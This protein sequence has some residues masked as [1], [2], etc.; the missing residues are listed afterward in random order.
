MLDN[1]GDRRRLQA[2]LDQLGGRWGLLTLGVLAAAPLRFNDLQARLG[3][4][5][6]TL[7]V[8]LSEAERHGLV[9]RRDY[10][11]VPKRVEY[12]LTARGRR[13]VRAS[14]PLLAWCARR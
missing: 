5:S 12:R 2:T 3:I 1:L 7:S 4:S 8:K 13:L 10:G 11:I 6:R 9:A 14:T